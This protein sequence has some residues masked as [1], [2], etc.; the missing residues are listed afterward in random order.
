MI[1]TIVTKV[2]GLLLDFCLQDEFWAEAVN[3]VVYLH[4]RCPSRSVG[5]LTPYEKL[6]GVKP[7]LG[8]LRRF[9]CTVYKLI[10]EAQQTRKF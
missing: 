3:T 2:G 8:H 9:S 4:A 10:P 5:G 7:E 6:F 1:R